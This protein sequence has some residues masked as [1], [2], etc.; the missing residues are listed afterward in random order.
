MIRQYFNKK[1][2]EKLYGLGGTKFRE[3]ISAEQF[4]AISV[5]NLFPLGEMP[6]PQFVGVEKEVTKYKIDFDA[7]SIN[8]SV[9][10][11]SAD[12]LQAF[13]F[14]PYAEQNKPLAKITS[15]E[16]LV[17]AVNTAAADY[18]KRKAAAGLSIGVI[19]AGKTT[20]YHYGTTE[21][22][23]AL[24]PNNRT[25][26]EIGSITKTFTALLLADA[27][28]EGKV[29]L[30]DPLNKY[31][32]LSVPKLA[33]DGTPVTLKTLANHTSGL[34]RMSNNFD[35]VKTDAEDPY[36]LYSDKDLMLFLKDF[37][38]KK[39][40]GTDYQYSNLGM[41]TLGRVL[42]KVYQKS[43]ARLVAEKIANPLG[44]AE[45]KQT[46][47]PAEEARFAKGYN[48]KGEL[49]KHWNFKV[50]APTGALR[51]TLADMTVYAKE[52]LSTASPIVG[53]A[54]RETQTVTFDDGSNK[55][56]LAW[57][58]IKP[59]KAE[60][61]FHNGG[62]YGFRSYLAVNKK[63]GTAVVVLSNSGINA[64]AVGNGLMTALE[65][66]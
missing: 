29:K 47:M 62:T 39:K 1:S 14:R 6:E 23:K 12:K 4:N 45:T 43:F 58:Y 24:L 59:G 8:L 54:M 19:R 7:A 49:T 42:E 11:D 44:M 22:G 5:N 36:K 50:Y 13:L 60:L 3:A 9:S 18:L 66:D 10:L 20:F 33:F 41:A 16:S 51:S 35:T 56:G 31:L 28:M 61:I 2:S 55:L 15:G 30:D 21:K 46:L 34:P 26:Y 57:H 40:P 63:N 37:R 25:F 48:E 17:N 52:V 27:V 32:P 38:L 53:K 64:D 65:E